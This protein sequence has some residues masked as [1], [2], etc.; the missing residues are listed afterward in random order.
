M[1]RNNLLCL[2]SI[3]LSDPIILQNTATALI[4]V[5][6][7]DGTQHQFEIKNKYEYRLS[8]Q[9]LSLLR[10]AFS[11]PLLNYG[12]FSEEFRLI[13]PLSRADF[14]LLNDLNTT[15]SR[16]IFVNKIAQGSNPYI[17]PEFF[18]DTTAITPNDG[19]PHAVIRP[20]QIIDDAP[21][22]TDVDPMKSGVLSSGGKD[23][24]L[25]YGL[26]KELGSTVYPLYINES[27]GHWKT[28]LT[29]YRYHSRTDS[30]TR[31]VWTNIDRFYTFML[32]HLRFI[33]PDHR[34]MWYDT[35]PLRLCIF[36][37]YI[38]SLLPLFIN[39][40]IGNILLGSEFDDLR[41]N[42]RYQGI[43]HYFGIYDQ[44]QDF[45]IRMNQ[46]YS[47]RIPGL[48]QWSALRNISGLVD[49]NIL[50]R[51]YPALA[52]LQRSCHSCHIKNNTVYPCGS[53]SKCLGILLYLLAN[54]LDPL[55]MNYQKK[56]ID[57]FY[58]NVGASSLKLDKDEKDQS[59]F[60]L[61][62][63]GSIPI[64]HCVDHVQKIHI[65]PQTC[66]LNLFPEKYREKLLDIFEKYTTGYCI[67]QEQQWT[68]TAGVHRPSISLGT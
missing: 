57:C 35:Y 31:R 23:S 62:Q 19:D 12:L 21:L 42:L 68:P 66:D 18:P 6:E 48:Y 7:S 40:K 36:P 3:S 25:T 38:F 33:R 5:T 1:T 60:L 4:V 37:F 46:W 28:A 52:K 29:A 59:F 58:A 16:D 61:R 14:S 54:D 49:E 10:L 26:L 41:Y 13:F 50:V 64:V 43:Q 15:F 39:E 2:S 8:Q 34:T 56:D 22:I 47:Q 11:M 63:H 32:D 65:D 9:H 55:L 17:L 27:G 20:T 45:D 44:H 30:H 51:R 24:L 53:C 67:L